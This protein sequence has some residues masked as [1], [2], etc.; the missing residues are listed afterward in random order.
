MWKSSRNS[1]QTYRVTHLSHSNTSFSLVRLKVLALPL[2]LDCGSVKSACRLC[3]Q[4]MWQES[5]PSTFGTVLNESLWSGCCWDWS[6]WDDSTH[7]GIDLVWMRTP[8]GIC[9]NRTTSSDSGGATVVSELGLDVRSHPDCS[10]QP[11]WRNT[12]AW[13]FKEQ[14]DGLHCNY[15]KYKNWEIWCLNLIMLKVLNN[16]IFIVL[17]TQIRKSGA[18]VFLML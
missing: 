18:V 13:M 2:F 17:Q 5:P 12:H 11:C 4:N 6:V 15:C 16:W 1:K 14:S 7:L 3:S 9:L 8:K 10:A